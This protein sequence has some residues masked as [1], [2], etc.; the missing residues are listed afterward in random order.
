MDSE[1][2][3]IDKI[4]NRH[5]SFQKL[6]ED[7]QSNY[8]EKI[9]TNSSTE[10]IGSDKVL[11]YAFLLYNNALTKEIKTTQKEVELDFEKVYYLLRSLDI[12]A[13]EEQFETVWGIDNIDT[14]V[15]YYFHLAVT[16][17]LS[18]N[19]IK[20]QVDLKKYKYKSNDITNW[21]DKLITQVFNAVILL[22]RKD[23]VTDIKDGLSIIEEL[24]QIQETYEDSFLNEAGESK[25][26][27]AINLIGYY[28]IC[29]LLIE[30][31][32]YLLQGYGY[33][34]NLINIITRHTKYA[35]ESLI[36][37]PRIQNCTNVISQICKKL[38]SN[39]IWTQTS[40]LSTNIKALCKTLN[41]KN[42]I[43]LL[44][45]Q[46]EAIKNN[47]LDPASS[48]TI[49]QMPT[50]A[51]K[52]LLAE[53]AILQTKAL[54]PDA[55]IVYLVP[56]RALINQVMGDLR[57]DFEGLNIDI[58]KCS[59]AIEL[60][61]SED[62]FLN[63]KIDIL[64]ATPEK[65]DLLIRKDHPVTHDIS[66]VIVDE[67]HNI[68]NG[69]RGARLELL[70]SILKREKPNLRYLLLTP[71][72]PQKENGEII[73]DWLSSG[74]TSIPPILVDWKPSDK[75]FLGIK[76][77]KNDFKAEILPSLY[78]W[79]IKETD[80]KLGKPE[81]HSTAKKERLF[82]FNAKH[83]SNE[84]KS[85]LFLCWGKGTADKKANL[86]YENLDVEIK[87]SE[88][89]NL[90]SR[91]IEEVVG[92]P[93]TISKVLKKGIAVHHAGLTDE[94]KLL[95]EHLIKQREVSH[96][97]ATTTV[98]Q[99]INFPIS[100]IHFDDFRKGSSGNL[101]ISEF[102]NIVGRAGRTLV[103]NV[104][105]ILF[106]FNSKTNKDKAREYL[107]SDSEEITS[108]LLDLILK[109]EKIVNAF[110]NSENNEE[111][112][113]LF[114]DNQ[115]LSSL[116]QY[117]IHLLNISNDDTFVD[118]IEDLFKD[119]LGYHIVD[120]EKKARFIQIC[121]TLYFSL[122]ENSSSG[123]LSY[124]D[125]TGFSVPSVLEIMK[126]KSSN[127]EILNKENWDPNNLF[128]QQDYSSMT[129]KV[130]IIAHLREVGL[131][132]DSTYSA[133]NPETVSKILVDWVN[134]D[135]ISILSKIHPSF[136][137]K[138]ED[139]INDFVS[140][141]T[142]ATFKSS[143]GLSA[144]EGIVNAKGDN[145]Q[146][147]NSYIPSMV[148]YGVRTKEAI[149]LRMLGVPRTLSDN[150]A[151]NLFKEKKPR[152][153][154][155]IRKSINNLSFNAWEDFKPNGSKLNGD[156]WKEITNILLR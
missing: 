20:V 71:F 11:R 152:S 138:G 41:E 84:D 114:K 68:S 70:L 146:D 66:L 92:E 34:E 65:F 45:S 91:Y 143:W 135:N 38:H 31:S 110:S 30:T 51:G 142:S 126:A 94:I 3:N 54:I 103:D 67:A 82:E 101:S 40:S 62:L 26:D 2:L 98:A 123:I 97:C 130:S 15:I 96:I 25:V 21:E 42:I 127:P 23:G 50:S 43:D 99:G 104:G 48:A 118:E 78:D 22:I 93:T 80:I 63:S 108:A 134:G 46:Q 147:T 37:K 27:K 44:P 109:S 83:F 77:H 58:E 90:V 39:C 153:Y 61:P 132:T 100:T 112:K 151:T 88:K 87:K 137:N 133:F 154:N 5:S 16:G 119:S 116:I 95:V 64:I 149:A 7:S 144:L 122:K 6:Y 124:A 73:R 107:K 150:I 28:H 136:R 76:E 1:T 125:K 140:Y 156:E 57:E 148:Y 56:T 4:L 33:G 81:I 9:L 145:I 86:L 52:T 102:R 72:I 35:I 128:S 121:Q 36:N 69:Q 89:V 17:L 139:R 8:V 115:A 113:E 12:S 55:K 117:I 24:K 111:R 74:K 155:E 75:I 47:F 85:I 129:N 79:T 19:D 53:F 10:T 13:V 49:L 18:N 29:K 105:K 59:G 14:K 60:D 131:G 120:D 141:L 106:P 32:N